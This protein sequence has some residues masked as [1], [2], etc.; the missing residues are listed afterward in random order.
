MPSGKSR[1]AS[2]QIKETFVSL[3]I[4][5]T[6][7][8]RSLPSRTD[9]WNEDF[10][11]T[12][13][14]ANE[15]EIAVYDKQVGDSQPVLIGLLWIR[16]SDLVEALRR[17]KVLTESGQGGWVTA[18]AMGR[19]PSTNSMPP[20]PGEQTSPNF[21]SDG[22]GPG[23][24]AYSGQAEGIDAWFSVEPAGAIALRLN[25][26]KTLVI[27]SPTLVES[28]CSS[29]KENIRKRPLD[30]PGGLGRQGAVR[31]RKGE[32]HEM[33]GHKFVQ[34]QFYQLMLCA[35]CSDFLLNALGYQCEDCRYTCHKKCHEKV[36]T[37]CISKS[38]TVGNAVLLV[39]VRSH[40]SCVFRR[41]MKRRLITASPID[42]NP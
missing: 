27:I 28:P 12:V 36:V 19:H 10:E 3:K 24:V 39:A 2:K 21:A 11:M 37:K 31:K 17:Q 40:P 9:R 23:A 5:G 8:A 22:P 35:F 25:F 26:G 16:I 42:S 32:V 41:A 20:Y 38:N 6:Q 33:N 13:D 30:A 7:R 15:V 1:S 29:V 18:G 34:K 14:K 4:E